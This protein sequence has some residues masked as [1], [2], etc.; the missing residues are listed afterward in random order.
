MRPVLVLSLCTLAAC[1]PLERQCEAAAAV[2]PSL[3]IG[4]GSD[5]FEPIERPV[6]LSRGLQGGS[7]MWLS[8]EIVG[9]APGYGRAVPEPSIDG[10]LLQGELELGSVSEL[11]EPMR[12][13]AEF[14]TVVGL[15][16]RTYDEYWYDDDLAAESAFQPDEAFQVTVAL[17]DACGTSVS[18]ETEVFID[19]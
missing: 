7:H 16:L 4:T 5:A 3:V 15:E 9:L 18:A 12:G 2:E 11:W 8:L 6:R 14:A 19:R 13:S 10:R 1:D 17:E